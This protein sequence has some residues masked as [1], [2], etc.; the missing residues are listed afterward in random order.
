M[1]EK[2]NT[3]EVLVGK[4][5]RKRQLSRSVPRW[6]ENITLDLIEIGWEGMDWIL[7]AQDREK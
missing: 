3:C 5:E 6:G 1:G 4:H 7:L 2:R